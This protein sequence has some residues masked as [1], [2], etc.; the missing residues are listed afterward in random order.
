[1]P[2]WSNLRDVLFPPE[3]RGK[4]TPGRVARQ[5]VHRR[6]FGGR[7]CLRRLLLASQ[8]FHFY[9]KP[10]QPWTTLPRPQAEGWKSVLKLGRANLFSQFP[11]PPCL[12]AGAKLY[13]TNFKHFNPH[14]T[15]SCYCNGIPLATIRNHSKKM[16]NVKCLNN[17][18][19]SLQ[20]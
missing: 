8:L 14:F 12:L 17:F 3:F 9:C 13:L 5:A 19:Q 11:H 2:S 10:P 15:V 20:S 16:L 1:M 4:C 18:F 7:W 6:G